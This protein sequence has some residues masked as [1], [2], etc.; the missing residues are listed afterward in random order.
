MLSLLVLATCEIC[1]GSREGCPEDDGTSEGNALALG[2]P[3]GPVDGFE[4]GRELAE[5]LDEGTLESEGV[6]VT[7]LLGWDEG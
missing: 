2:T 3:E 6:A 7:R 1:V 4:E 5:G